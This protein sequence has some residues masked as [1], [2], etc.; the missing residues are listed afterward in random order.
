MPFWRRRGQ[1]KANQNAAHD[2]TTAASNTNNPPITK[3]DRRLSSLVGEHKDQKEEHLGDAGDGAKQVVLVPAA[4]HGA[5]PTTTMEARPSLLR[6]TISSISTK[7]FAKMRSDSSK[8]AGQQTNP[9]GQAGIAK[10]TSGGKHPNETP[11]SAETDHVHR[12]G[13]H[14]FRSRFHTTHHAPAA[15]AAPA[16]YGAADHGLHLP[17]HLRHIHFPH[18]L[19]H[20]AQHSGTSNGE[21]E[22][23][24]MMV[25][26]AAASRATKIVERARGEREV[27]MER[28]REEAE[29]EIKELRRQLEEQALKDQEKDNGEDALRAAL[30]E[31][32]ARMRHIL[33]QA[34]EH[35]EASVSLCVAHVL[36]VD[37]SL[38]PDRR[39]ALRNL[40]KN[41]PSFL[42]KSN[43]K[44]YPS[45]RRVQADRITKGKRNMHV[46]DFSWNADGPDYQLVDNT[47]PEQ[48][49][50]YA[51]ILGDR[52]L[53]EGEEVQIDFDEL[54]APAPLGRFSSAM[55]SIHT[56]CGCLLG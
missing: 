53:K 22:T 51:T 13:F 2:S 43:A 19:H 37:T 34:P 55:Q 18:L 52:T 20:T 48:E 29:Q 46:W 6:R 41:P 3:E 24:V 21:R 40:S 28:A 45:E 23:D 42:R 16:Q 32:D 54:E 47:S 35:M 25:L 11:A 8:V 30:A 7:V 15:Q 56:T 10:T 33:E 27:L 4:A 1:A 36:N 17:L 49:D 39:G 44:S 31:E 14:G 50:L 38:A 26:Q 12:R 5:S 9:D